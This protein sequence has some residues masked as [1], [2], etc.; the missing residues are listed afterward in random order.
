MALHTSESKEGRLKG[1]GGHANQKRGSLLEG[2]NRLSWSDMFFSLQSTGH[3]AMLF[4][5]KF[6]NFSE[7]FEFGV[8][9]KN[10]KRLMFELLAQTTQRNDSN[11]NQL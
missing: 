5:L 1:M 10:K 9:K 7:C 4:P 8:K 6:C 11:R 3:S 2:E